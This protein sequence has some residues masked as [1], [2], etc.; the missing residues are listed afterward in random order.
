MDSFLRHK[1]TIIMA[2]RSFR[3]QSSNSISRKRKVVFYFNNDKIQ[4]VKILQ[5]NGSM[6]IRRICTYSLG[7]LMSLLAVLFV[8]IQD[9]HSHP[10]PRRKD[11]PFFFTPV[12]NGEHGRVKL[13]I[14]WLLFVRRQSK[15]IGNTK[16]L[17]CCI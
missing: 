16:L 3:A 13:R 4:R 1:R 14:R 6:S 15:R 12:S 2:F 10:F 11:A 9:K 5:V 17:K 8:L 7:R